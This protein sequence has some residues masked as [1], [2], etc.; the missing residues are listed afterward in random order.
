MSSLYDDVHPGATERRLAQHFGSLAWIMAIVFAVPFIILAL[1]LPVV[2]LV[3]AF[4]E[5]SEALVAFLR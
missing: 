5:L 2:L 3:R 4:V 1:G